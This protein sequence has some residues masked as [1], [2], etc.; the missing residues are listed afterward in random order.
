MATTS[1]L[2]LA[3]LAVIDAS[4][5]IH[6]F[7]AAIG[8]SIGGDYEIAVECI[9]DFNERQTVDGIHIKLIDSEGGIEGGGEYAHRIWTVNEGS[10]ILSHIRVTG[11]YSSWEGTDWS[12]DW[13]F[14]YPRETIVIKYFENK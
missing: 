10:K 1:E 2:S 11:Y 9:E 14:V 5:F 8:S 13:T 7:V 6:A 4:Q 3:Q 12:G